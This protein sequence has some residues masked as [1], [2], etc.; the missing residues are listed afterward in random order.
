MEPATSALEAPGAGGQVGLAR[1]LL[2][3]HRQRPL[4]PVQ[5][6]HHVSRGY[7]PGPLLQPQGVRNNIYI[8]IYVNT[9]FIGYND[10]V[11]SLLLSVTLF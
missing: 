10:S 9:V 4:P 6:R 5:E 11:S 3:A 1:A 2:G 8:T 7:P